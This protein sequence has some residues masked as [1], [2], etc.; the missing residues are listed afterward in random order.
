V[1]SRVASRVAGAHVLRVCFQV[2]FIFTLRNPVVR[3]Y[4]EYLNK[5]ADRT[6]VRYLK[7]RIDNKM[8][9]ELT[10]TSPPFEELIEDVKRTMELCGAP[11]RT[12]SMMDEYTPEMEKASCYVNPFVGEGRYARYLRLWLGIVPKRQM[13]L[14]NFDEWTHD[15][16][17]VMEAVSEFLQ[18][19]PFQA[20]G[21]STTSPFG[22]NIAAA[23]NTHLSRSVHIDRKGQSDVGALAK[24]SL[25]EQL[26]PSSHCVLHEFFVPYIAELAALLHEYDFPPMLWPTG[27]TDRFKCKDK[28]M[29]W[30][31]LKG[32]PIEPLAG[33]AMPPP[34][35]GPQP[36][37]KAVPAGDAPE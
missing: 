37:T 35:T 19:P 9:K 12:F 32:K 11:N 30:R 17:R 25:A 8:E 21:V 10:D 6:V 3:A 5:V 26:P 1:Q 18:L 29:F 36:A 7:K 33:A 28:F 13:M 14:L 15:A 27:R 22:Y 2:R 23:H 34:S 31:G 24:E 16:A 4:S 20:K